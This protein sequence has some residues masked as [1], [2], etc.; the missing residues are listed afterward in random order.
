MVFAKKNAIFSAILPKI[1]NS[2]R[3]GVVYGSRCPIMRSCD[4]DLLIGSKMV[5]LMKY[6]DKTRKYDDS[7]RKK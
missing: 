4:G 7:C 5:K 6:S 1:E 3:G 2:G